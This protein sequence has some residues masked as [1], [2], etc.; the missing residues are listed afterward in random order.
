MKKDLSLPSPSI[1]QTDKSILYPK[2]MFRK[3]LIQVLKYTYDLCQKS[4]YS[5]ISSFIFPTVYKHF[6]I[7]RETPVS[8]VSHKIQTP[9]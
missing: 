5:C 6:M 1:F 8:Y 2:I 3:Q 9:H 4:K 7:A